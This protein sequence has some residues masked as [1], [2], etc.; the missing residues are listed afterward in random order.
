M[1]KKRVGTTYLKEKK[2]KN[3]NYKLKLEIKRIKK[4]PYG[5]LYEYKWICKKI[6]VKK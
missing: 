4:K 5:V 3:S 6:K 2:G 1:Y